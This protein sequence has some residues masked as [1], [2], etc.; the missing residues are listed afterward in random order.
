MAQRRT[1][2][3]LAMA[4]I[5]RM[6][7]KTPTMAIALLTAVEHDR[8]K[9]KWIKYR[10]LNYVNLLAVKMQK[11]KDEKKMNNTFTQLP[12]HWA[13]KDLLGFYAQ[14]VSEHAIVERI[15]ILESL[16][17]RLGPKHCGRVQQVLMGAKPE[18]VYYARHWKGVHRLLK[19]YARYL[20]DACKAN[21]SALVRLQRR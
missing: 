3:Q 2:H 15:A 16:S 8:I 4:K 9:I 12:P 10:I 7:P 13:D 18:G 5:Y 6:A 17:K 14:P 11:A 20:E 21:G 1:E 19:R